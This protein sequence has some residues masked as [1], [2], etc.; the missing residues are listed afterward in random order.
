RCDPG[1]ARADRLGGVRNAC[2]RRVLAAQLEP[3]ADLALEPA[4]QDRAAA[5]SD[6]SRRPAGLPRPGPGGLRR[7]V[8]G[9]LPV[10]AVAH[11][12][13]DDRAARRNRLGNARG[14]DRNSLAR[15]LVHPLAAAVRG[16]VTR[17]AVAPGDAG[18]VRVDARDCGA[19]ELGNPRAED[20][21]ER[22]VRA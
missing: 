3:E 20:V 5:R 16:T 8:R 10:A 9:R 1:R 14:P 4:L 2:A 7:G 11:L 15:A 17:H 21:A 18:H 12:G 22:D 13:W 19:A 6:P